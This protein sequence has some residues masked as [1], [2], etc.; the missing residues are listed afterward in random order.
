MNQKAIVQWIMEQFINKES[1]CVDMTLGNGN[2]LVRMAK[3]STQGEL[4]G[5]DIQEEAIRRSKEKFSEGSHIH[6]ILDSHE[7]FSNYVKSPIDFAIYNLGYLPGGD[8]DIYT[9]VDSTLG[10]LKQLLTQLKV[11]GNVVITAYPGHAMGKRESLKIKELLSTLSQKS[12]EVLFF[13]LLNQIN[14][15]P[16]VYWI[17]KMGQ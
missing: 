7:N 3:L 10:S 11:G 1:L 17:R 2:D 16:E 8:K 5:F 14:N 15:P 13:D 9:M 6:L 12:Y 4:Y